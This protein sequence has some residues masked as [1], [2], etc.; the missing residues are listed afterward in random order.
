MATKTVICL[1]VIVLSN[2][3][4]NMVRAATRRGEAKGGG[5]PL[6]NPPKKTAQHIP[7]KLS[8]PL[9]QFQDGGFFFWKPTETS[10]KS[11]PQWRDDLFFGKQ[12]RTW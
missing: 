5:A 7:P 6:N 11:R 12:Q 4:G 10:E 2:F 1:S 9:Q 3:F 8:L